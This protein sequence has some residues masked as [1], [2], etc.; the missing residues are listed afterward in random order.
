MKGLF[1]AQLVG[2]GRQKEKISRFRQRQAERKRE[3]VKQG[4]FEAFCGQMIRELNNRDAV[5][6]AR[7]R[8]NR[9]EL[10]RSWG[11]LQDYKRVRAE[12]QQRKQHLLLVYTGSLKRRGL[13]GLAVFRRDSQLRRTLEMQAFSNYT[14]QLQRACKA[15]LVS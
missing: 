14:S 2:R 3:R 8:G 10:R 5:R 7:T 11:A 1:V 9:R 13:Q 6:E 15:Y 4:Y 12:S